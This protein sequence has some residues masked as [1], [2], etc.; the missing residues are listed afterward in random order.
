MDMMASGRLAAYAVCTILLVSCASH[1]TRVVTAMDLIGAADLFDQRGVVL[2]GRVENPASHAP[3]EGEP[4]PTFTVVDA[5]GRVPVFSTR[6]LAVSP[7]EVVE[8]RDMFRRTTRV[9]KETLLDTVEATTVRPLPTD[10][11]HRPGSE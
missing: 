10:D 4:Y 6:S 1:R 2:T 8:V 3:A 5:T 7:G 9:G 11:G